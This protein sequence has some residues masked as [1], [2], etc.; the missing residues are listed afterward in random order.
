MNWKRLF[1]STL[2]FYVGIFMIGLVFHFTYPLVVHTHSEKVFVLSFFIGILV[3][4]IL[5][6]AIVNLQHRGKHCFYAWGLCCLINALG[7]LIAYVLFFKND[8]LLEVWFKFSMILFTIN[9][10]G[11]ALGIPFR[12]NQNNNQKFD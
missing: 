7:A 6:F 3:A 8:R 11:I 12:K 9:I 1:L 2:L 10:I 4:I 5:F